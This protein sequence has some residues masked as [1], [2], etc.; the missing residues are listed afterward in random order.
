MRKYES[1]LSPLLANREHT[2]VIIKPIR[3]KP[4]HKN[5]VNRIIGCILSIICIFAQIY[6]GLI[7]LLL[8]TENNAF[9]NIFTHI[10]GA[11]SLL[12]C[13]MGLS[14]STLLFILFSANYERSIKYC[15][16]LVIFMQANLVQ[17]FIW[18]ILLLFA[19]IQIISD[20]VDLIFVALLGISDGFIQYLTFY[21]GTKLVEDDA[22]DYRLLD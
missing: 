18:V 12:I 2:G 4:R 13:I 17:A 14:G 19:Y 22:L 10:L 9:S 1:L 16:I 3:P 7:G 21:Y 11:Y 5:V 15:I 8:I 6:Y 20:S